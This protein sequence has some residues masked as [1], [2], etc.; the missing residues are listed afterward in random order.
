MTYIVIELQVNV[1]GAVSNLVYAYTDRQQA[2][3]KYHTILAAAAVSG[4]P[5]HSAV[6]IAEDGTPIQHQCY[7]HDVAE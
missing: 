7:R 5:C 1:G 3:N 6:M 2:E 4:L